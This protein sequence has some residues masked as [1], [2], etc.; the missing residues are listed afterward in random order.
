MADITTASGAKIYIGPSIPSSTDTAAEFAALTWVEIGLVESLGEFGDEASISTFASL[1]D[2]RMRKAKGVRDAG[3]LA[4]TAARTVDDP[5]QIALEAAEATNNKFAFK[6]EYPD[7]PNPTGTNSVDYFR[8]LVTSKRANVGDANNI[9]RRTYS[10]G[11]DSAI[12]TVPAAP[13]N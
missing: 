9:I 4:I 7:K 5:G 1:N 6:V 8:A 13:G 11:I 3:T 12:I 2:A 10:L